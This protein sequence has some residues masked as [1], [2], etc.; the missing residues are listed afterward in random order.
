MDDMDKILLKEEDIIK[1]ENDTNDELNISNEN[2]LVSIKVDLNKDF[3][4]VTYQCEAFYKKINNS[5][6]QNPYSLIE[7]ILIENK[8]NIDY[9]DLKIIFES[10][11]PIIDISDINISSLLN[12]SK[13]GI[14]ENIYMKIKAIDVYNISEAIPSVLT[15]KL[16]N[17]DGII[18][19]INYDVMIHPMDECS[20]IAKNYQMISCYVTPN[21]YFVKKLIVEASIELN[22]ITSD[23]NTCFYGYQSND[24]DTVLDEMKAIYNALRKEKIVYSHLLLSYESFQRIRI[25]NE[26]LTKKTGTCLDLAILYCACLESIGLNPIIIFVDGH[27]F[28]GCFLE[29]NH[30]AEKECLDAAQIYNSSAETNMIIGLVECTLFTGIDSASFEQALSSAR[31]RLELYHGSFSAIDVTSCHASI[32]RP[33]P[34][35]IPD[36][37]NIF[38]VDEKEIEIEYIESKKHKKREIYVGSKEQENKFAYWSRKLLDLSTRN[39]LIN[40]YLG[41]ANPQILIDSSTSLINKAL[42]IPSIHLIP[43]NK[44]TEKNIYYDYNTKDPSLLLNANKN[45]YS[46]VTEDSEMIRLFRKA[47]SAIEEKGSNILFISVG[48]VCFIPKNS[49]KSFLAPV[50][51][52]PIKGKQR[53]D[54]NGFEITFMSNDV[55]INTTLFEYLKVECD[56]NFDELYSLGDMNGLENVDIDSVYN[57]IRAK[58]CDNCSISVDDEKAFLATFSFDNYIIWDDIRTR[59]EE[60]LKNKIISSF[61]SN[62]AFSFENEENVK[63]FDEDNIPSDIAIPLGA[64]S[65]QIEAI[66]DCDRGESFV[67]D[68]PP[69]TGKSQTIV[70]MIV[71]SMYHNKKILFVAEKKAALSVVKERLDKINLGNFCLEL[72]S[73]NSNKKDFLDQIDKALQY[74]HIKSPN[75]LTNNS[76]ELLKQRYTLNLLIEKIHKKV[77]LEP[78]YDCI[79][80]YTE[81]KDLGFNKINFLDND[82]KLYQKFTDETRKDIDDILEKFKAIT[83]KHGEYAL[84][85]FYSFDIKDFNFME[86][87]SLLELLNIHFDKTN[88]FV[89]EMKKIEE[90]LPEDLRFS[91]LDE[92]TIKKIITIFNYLL[93]GNIIIKNILSKQM[94]NTNNKNQMVINL[95]LENDRIYKEVCEYY[96]DNIFDYNVKES[97]S[98]IENCTNKI[99][100]FFVKNKI[101]KEIKKFI[102]LEKIKSKEIKV[103]RNNI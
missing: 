89:I 81:L 18:S 39:K 41:D 11:N 52:I 57:A 93:K 45:I 36:E 87:N 51:L 2:N 68:G 82:E 43:I 20:D 91:K 103:N 53:K 58:N 5:N 17:K 70:N 44:R 33:I 100:L 38:K 69:G 23:P 101:I 64:D 50:F 13:I 54:Q 7:K 10:S 26:V 97:I 22:K 95:G 46:I 75:E 59:K 83:V 88:D 65:S 79:V 37:N 61:V 47:S 78:L 27:A 86:K 24:I 14:T 49:K 4:Y 8:S 71:N 48:M 102:H 25:P 30:F 90:L 92:V 15:I 32:F 98:K 63:T 19:K 73:N 28:A 12:N 80:K 9:H 60:L 77:Y 55:S 76:N 35:K 72:H 40:M 94:E 99:K 56:I 96:N 1:E 67:L 3:S 29:D 62:Q 6:K 31:K 21:D 16:T 34:T 85:P 66:L 74:S 42:S 84:N